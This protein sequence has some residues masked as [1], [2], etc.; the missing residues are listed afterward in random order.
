[1][2]RRTVLAVAAILTVVVAA[3]SPLRAQTSLVDL[4]VGYQWV[5]VS[6]ND[7]MYRTQLNDD[8]GFVLRN[9]S[10]NLI[11]TGDSAGI[12]DRFR[13]D[14]SGFG[15]SPAGK[16]GLRA[17]LGDVYSLRVSYSHFE[18]YS[19][20][21]GWANPFVGEGVVPGQHTFDRDRDL[22]DVEVEL[23]PGRVFSPIVGYRWNRYDGPRRTTYHAGQDEF[24]LD[25]DLEETEEEF[26]LGFAFR[27]GSW[28]GSVIQGWR[29]FESTE[30]ASL[31]PGAGGG[32]NSGPVL[33]VD[34]TADTLDRTMRTEAE[35][36]VT[37]AYLSGNA[38]DRVRLEASFVHADWDGDSSSNEM[39]SGSL[40]SYQI[41]RYFASMDQSV[42]SRTESPSWRGA[43]GATIDLSPSVQLE[44]GYDA[45]H[46]ELEGWSM[47]SELYLGTVNFSGADPRDISRLVETRSRYE[48]EDSV[49][50]VLVRARDLG[51]FEV[52]AGYTRTDSDI[53]IDQDVAE[54]VAPWGQEGEYDRAVDS[55]QVGTSVSWESLTLSVDLAKDDAD[56]LVMRSDFLD[57][58]RI[59]GRFDWSPTDWLQVLGTA[60]Q[61]DWD[62]TSDEGAGLD[63][64][65]LHWAVDLAL[66]PSADLV[67][68]A[69]YDVYD[70][71][72]EFSYRQPDDFEMVPSLH[73]EEGDMLEGSIEW[74]AD[75]FFAMAGYST[76]SNDGTFPFDLDRLFARLGYDFSQTFGASVEVE[77][78]DYSEDGLGLGDFEADRYGVYLRFRP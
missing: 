76:F 71:E 55:F 78:H 44:L 33:G 18:M 58:T 43:L 32:N 62:S 60:E 59:R 36:P 28:R 16:L 53:D 52:W 5:E 45:R 57:R 9:L 14:A 64:D 21:P 8:D 30:T 3:G 73:S 67:I 40:V 41:M 20:L 4:E 66:R 46:R 51:R 23:F 34:P 75:Q 37:S 35:T 22:L 15:G 39:L 17:D 54:M 25:S 27:A 56:A 48:R 11:D 42:A 10:V 6:G 74:H 38:G 63:A 77:N 50:D 47:I 29:E 1:M 7:D 70:T 68:R 12:Y 26:R 61:L 65:T 69:A 49:A 72:S 19:A 2:T 31:A 13:L 24:R